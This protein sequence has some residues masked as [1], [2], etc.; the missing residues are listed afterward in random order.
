VELGAPDASGSGVGSFCDE[1]TCGLPPQCSKTSIDI[2]LSE[3]SVKRRIEFMSVCPS[4]RNDRYPA[5]L[6][7]SM[8]RGAECD[9]S[10]NDKYGVVTPQPPYTARLHAFVRR[11][12]TR[13][14]ARS[15]STL[16]A[17]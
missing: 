11:A 16:T 5:R 9:Q 13:S 2:K 14:R 3:A 17:K 7:I 15:V 1:L 12:P 4:R 6:S 10:S 8:C